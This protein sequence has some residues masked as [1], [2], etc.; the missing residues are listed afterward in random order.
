MTALGPFL[1]TGITLATLSLLGTTPVGKEQL[2]RHVKGPDRRDFNIF[3]IF[4]GRLYGPVDLD[5]FK[6]LISSSIS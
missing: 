2:K 3:N 4:V 6:L 1:C 5:G